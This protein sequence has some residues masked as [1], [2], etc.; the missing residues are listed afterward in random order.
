MPSRGSGSLSG[1]VQSV[2]VALALAVWHGKG[3]LHPAGPPSHLQRLLWGALRCLTRLLF[4]PFLIDVQEFFIYYGESS[5]V[6]YSQFSTF[7]KPFSMW[8]PGTLTHLSWVIVFSLTRARCHWLGHMDPMGSTIAARMEPTRHTGSPVGPVWPPAS[9]S[10][11][12]TSSRRGQESRR[13]SPRSTRVETRTVGAGSWLIW[14]GR[15]WGTSI[16]GALAGPPVPTAQTS[17]ASQA[18]GLAEA[19]PGNTGRGHIC[20][21]PHLAG[22][23]PWWAARVSLSASR[24]AFAFWGGPLRSA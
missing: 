10:L 20:T 23:H 1:K 17:A 12:V 9:W 11:G 21:L 2:H 16:S 22:L 13:V 4:S 5:S 18:G 14:Q 24:S 6:G 7:S 15:G 3:G 8:S 19:G